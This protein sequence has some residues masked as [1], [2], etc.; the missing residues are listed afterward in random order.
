LTV[1]DVSVIVPVYNTMPYLTAC[2]DSLVAQTI[3]PDRL[4]VIAVDDGS[5][6]GSGAEID[7]FVAEHP[8]FVQAVHQPNSG[9]PASPCNRG[10]EVATGRYVFF[11]GGDDYLGVETLDRLVRIADQWES[12]VL[13]AKLVSA[14]GR[15]VETKM[16]AEQAESLDLFDSRLPYAMSNTKLFRRSLIE[17]H[18]LRFPED[19]P[20]G[21]DQ[22]FTFEALLHSRRTS[23]V[24]DYDYYTAVRR[25]DSSNIT[26]SSTGRRRIDFAARMMDFVAARVDAGPRRDAILIRHFDWEI[27]ETLQLGYLDSAPED[28]QVVRETVERLVDDYLTEAVSARLGVAKRVRIRLAAAGLTDEL[29][30]AIQDEFGIDRRP[31]S[32]VVD[33]DRLFLDF[34]GFGGALPDD[35]YELHVRDL[36]PAM[37]KRVDVTASSS[38]SSVRVV[39]HVPV[40]TRGAAAQLAVIDRAGASIAAEPLATWPAQRTTDLDVIVPKASGLQLRIPLADTNVDLPIPNV[41]KRSAVARAGAAIRR[42]MREF[43]RT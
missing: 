25:E 30:Q 38:G 15:S 12:D 22:P 23:V 28:Q 7:R 3:G 2:L 4:E 39:A 34:A 29:E 35:A 27:N 42:R 40:V 19:L 17:D 37:K 20:M 10:L 6:D 16:Y 31:P 43:G 36:L 26:F 21:S 13:V 41:A 32:Y 11:V 9:G 18:N 5:T 24:N 14:G 1:P 33:G 8:E